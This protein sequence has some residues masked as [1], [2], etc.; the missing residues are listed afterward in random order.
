M[1]GLNDRAHVLI[2]FHPGR[3]SAWVLSQTGQPL[4]KTT[5]QRP[6]DS[7]RH[8]ELNIPISLPS[9]SMTDPLLWASLPESSTSTT[10]GRQENGA[11]G[12]SKNRFHPSTTA[13]LPRSTPRR[14]KKIASGA[15]KDPNA[16][17]SRAAIVAAKV[18]SAAKTWPRGSGLVFASA[19]TTVRARASA[20]IAAIVERIENS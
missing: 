13:A 17:R 1:R 8:T 18:L 15:T 12:P 9:G 6:S 3:Y 11:L 4:S 10:S 14:P 20:M 16:L 5:R 19:E 7:R 2:E